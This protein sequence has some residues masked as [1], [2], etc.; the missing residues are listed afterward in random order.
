MLKNVRLWMKRISRVPRLRQSMTRLWNSYE[1]LKFSLYNWWNLKSENWDSKIDPFQLYWVSPEVIMLP[2]SSTFDFITD[3]GK[4]YGGEWDKNTRNFKDDLYYRSFNQRFC[5]G[6]SW[7]QTP[8]YEN[9]REKIQN[10]TDPRYAT[11]AEFRE[12]LQ[13]Y[14]DMYKKFEQDGYLLQTELA[15]FEETSLPGNGG[16]ALFPSL[17]DKTLMRHE[18]AV[19]IGRDGTFIRNDGRHRLA[20]ALL[21]DLDEI[22]VRI[23]VR[24]TQWQAFRDRV[25]QA[26]DKSIEAGVSVEDVPKSVENRLDRE[27]DDIYLGLNHPDLE[28]IFNRYLSNR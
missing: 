16:R 1:H 22:P 24:H 13:L 9:R 21:T 3:S 2:T 26:I 5:R 8:I 6:Y 4:T 27:L 25:V 19:N 17:T 12:K 7:E 23:V 14:E 10:G 15:K 20:L 28:I 18:I 11:M